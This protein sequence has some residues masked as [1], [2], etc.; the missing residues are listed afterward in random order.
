MKTKQRYYTFVTAA[1]LALTAFSTVGLRLA[2][3]TTDTTTGAATTSQTTTGGA[4]TSG[5]SQTLTADQKA[6]LEKRLQTRVAAVK[7]KITDAQKTR[8]TARCKASQGNLTSF[9]A[10]I[11]TGQTKRTEA[12]GAVIAKLSPL[13]AS[14]KAQGVDTTKLDEQIKELRTRMDTYNTAVSDYKQAVTDLSVMDCVADP[15]GFQASLEAARTAQYGVRTAAQS[16]TDYIRNTIKPTLVTI[17]QGLDAS[18]ST[19]STSG[20]TTKSTTTTGS[21]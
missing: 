10:R 17:R 3:A 11:Q 14:L 9:A 8:I 13:A 1:T 5:S 2:H 7:T 12:Y 21:N 4:A 15:S 19:T 18:A 20:T 16:A 6:A